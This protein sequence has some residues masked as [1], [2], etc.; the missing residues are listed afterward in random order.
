[1][2]K[3]N[4]KKHHDAINKIKELCH[5][6]NSIETC[7]FLGFNEEDQTYIV[8]HEENCSPEPSLYF[9]INA[10]N[11]LSFKETYQTI[12]VFHSHIVGDSSPSEFDIKMS[13]NCCLPFLIYSLGGD[14]LSLYQPKNCDSNLEYLNKIKIFL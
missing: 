10:F 6:R 14:S 13:E 1:M 4:F 9:E 2:D 5:A 8:Q 12:C 7:G 3:Y 11:Y